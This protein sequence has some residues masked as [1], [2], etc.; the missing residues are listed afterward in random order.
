M[1]KVKLTDLKNDLQQLQIDFGETFAL[2]ARL[3]IV[4]AALAT[5]AQNKWKVYLM[6]LKSTLLYRILKEKNYEQQPLGYEVEGKED[7]AYRLKKVL[8]GLKQ[9]PRAWQRIID[10]YMIKNGLCRSNIKPTVYTKVNE[11]GKILIIFLYDYDMIYTGD[12]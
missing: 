2:V 8:Y 7:K 1:R 4:R 6:D 3:D 11:S 10:N 9:V 12:F 5:T